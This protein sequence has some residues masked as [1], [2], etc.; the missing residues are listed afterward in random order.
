[1]TDTALAVIADGFEAEA[2]VIARREGPERPPLVSSRIPPSWDEAGG[3]TFELFGQL[4]RFLDAGTG[5]QVGPV[6]PASRLVAVGGLHGWIGRQP[7]AVGLLGAAVVRSRAFT[8]E[9]EAILARVV[10]SVSVAVGGEGPDPGAAARLSATVEPAGEGWRAEVALA[11]RRAT[12]RG[13]RSELAVARAAAVLCPVPCHV[14]FAGRTR[15]EGSEV[16]IV[17]VDDEDRSPL[18]GLSVA[19]GE[20][21]AGPARAVLA[22]MAGVGHWGPAGP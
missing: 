18:I 22:A 13:R 14:A 15:V 12:A 11:G 20:A 16:T 5:P 17:V 9:E 4:W 21:T 3:L 10:R 19:A 1:V 6:V 7:T 8:R 2:V